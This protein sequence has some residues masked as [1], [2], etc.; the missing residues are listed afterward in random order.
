MG[1]SGLE[2]CRSCSSKCEARKS[3]GRLVRVLEWPSLLTTAMVGRSTR[4]RGDGRGHLVLSHSQADAPSTL[5]VLLRRSAIEN[6]SGFP[7]VF[8]GRSAEAGLRTVR[9]ARHGV[10][11]LENGR[12]QTRKGVS[13]RGY[14]ERERCCCPG[15]QVLGAASAGFHLIA[16]QGGGR[17]NY[18][19]WRQAHRKWS[20]RKL[21]VRY[22]HL[23]GLGRFE[24]LV[25]VSSHFSVLCVE[26]A[27]KYGVVQYLH[28][29][30]HQVANRLGRGHS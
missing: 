15:P 4:S 17:R 7:G 21:Q 20:R 22:V 28:A 23:L 11:V 19:W 12:K 13:G 3:L 25:A 8:G 26:R 16:S 10:G 18:L 24:L 14:I 29:N 30:T 2:C 1:W 5:Q 27:Y 6:A 9:F